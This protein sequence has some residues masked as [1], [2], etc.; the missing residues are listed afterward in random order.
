MNNVPRHSHESDSPK[1]KLIEMAA[2]VTDL[3]TN[4][5]NTARWLRAFRKNYRH[6][7][8]TF[9]TEFGYVDI[10][11]AESATDAALEAKPET[12]AA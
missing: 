4:A 5:V 2:R 7:A 6:M 8:V 11:E 10:R 9:G 3:E 1:T 12:K